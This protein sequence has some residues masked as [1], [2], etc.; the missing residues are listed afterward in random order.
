MAVPV[1]ESITPNYGLFSGGTVIVITGQNFS[2][3][4]SLWFEDG[5]M[6]YVPV[7][8]FSI[9]S[10]TQITV[11]TPDAQIARVVDVRLQNIFGNSAK[12]DYSKFTYYLLA[13]NKRHFILPEERIFPV[14][15]RTYPVLP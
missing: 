11:T 13:P 2:G 14:E 15:K 7:F 5:G 4:I 8:D 3:V 10:D 9:D 6:W 1:I 12:T